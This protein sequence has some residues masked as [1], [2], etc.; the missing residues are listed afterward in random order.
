MI[1]FKNANTSRRA[2]IE[3]ENQNKLNMEIKNLEQA[4]LQK[5]FQLSFITENRINFYEQEKLALNEAKLALSE[6]AEAFDQK[7]ADE[8][9][10]LEREKLNLVDLGKSFNANVIKIIKNTDTMEAYA[11]DEL[12]LEKVIEI[13]NAI[14]SYTRGEKIWDYSAPD[15][16][17][18]VMTSIP[19]DKDTLNFIKRRQENGGNIPAGLKLE[20]ETAEIILDGELGPTQTKAFNLALDKPASDLTKLDLTNMSDATGVENTII[21]FLGN[22]IEV[23]SG[24]LIDS[25][26]T[27]TQTAKANLNTLN[28]SLETA[29]Q[30]ARQGKD[31]EGIRK[32]IKSLVP[33]PTK[34]LQGDSVARE[35]AL[36][37]VAFVDTELS[38]QNQR[39]DLG[40][41]NKAELNEIQKNINTLTNLRNSYQLVYD[42]YN[43]NTSNSG[44]GKFNADGKTIDD[45]ITN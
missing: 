24:G 45:F 32:Q 8:K 40:A 37:V 36:A 38:I 9:L 23:V 17:A 27:K 13:N 16:G 30:Q 6:D 3:T 31:T 11:K 12:S 28:F 18:W 39:L 7:L 34:W 26:A 25:P 2:Q 29:I 10:T 21:N 44:S 1:K 42:S 41:A 14:T 19:L 4:R 5:D 43:K 20:G 15:G 35:K 22:A 33:D